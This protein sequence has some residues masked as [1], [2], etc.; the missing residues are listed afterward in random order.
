LG[1][2]SAQPSENKQRSGEHSPLS[3]S[4][5]VLGN[6]VGTILLTINVP[7]VYMVRYKV[8]VSPP[9]KPLCTAPYKQQVHWLFYVPAMEI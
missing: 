8:M 7:V 2:I 1:N 9:S 4:F 3:E 5:S 6:I